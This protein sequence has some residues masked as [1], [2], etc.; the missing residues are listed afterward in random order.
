MRIIFLVSR[1]VLLL[2]VVAVPAHAAVVCRFISDQQ[3]AGAVM[4]V[5]GGFY[6][7]GIV[8]FLFFK[9]FAARD[10]DA[11]D[12]KRTG[13]MS[14]TEIVGNEET[15]LTT[16]DVEREFASTTPPHADS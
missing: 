13:K 12:F 9:R 4:K 8:I 6:L 16:A 3:L 10:D 15:P 5:A 7:W 2:L 14:P 1:V 11:Y